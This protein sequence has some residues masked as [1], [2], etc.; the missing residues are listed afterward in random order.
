MSVRPPTLAPSIAAPADAS[1]LKSQ[2]IPILRSQQLI[3]RKWTTPTEGTRLAVERPGVQTV[4]WELNTK[5]WRGK[6]WK[7]LTR[8]DLKEGHI[9]QQSWEVKQ[10][11]AKE[12][13]AAREAEFDSGAAERTDRQAMVWKGR[14]KG[15]SYPLERLHL[16]TRRARNRPAKEQRRAEEAALRREAEQAAKQVVAGEN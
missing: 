7:N 3:T 4:M 11:L 6:M 5:D 14:P 1:F 15:I 10:C 13:L 9:A 16:S 12:A 8:P 2:I